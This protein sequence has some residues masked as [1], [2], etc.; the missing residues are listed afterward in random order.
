METG[1][2]IT[3]QWYVH[4]IYIYKVLVTVLAE[5]DIFPPEELYRLL[6]TDQISNVTC[7]TNCEIATVQIKKN[8]RI[9]YFNPLIEISERVQKFIDF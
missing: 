6:E 8:G 7:T 5:N 4:F 1:E 9:R 2:A 3:V